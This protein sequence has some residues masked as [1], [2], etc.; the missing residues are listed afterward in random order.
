MKHP[1][2]T[3]TGCCSSDQIMICTFISSSNWSSYI[4]S[5]W[6]QSHEGFS[7]DCLSEALSPVRPSSSGC[8]SSSRISETLLMFSMLPLHWDMRRSW[9]HNG[10]DVSSCTQVRTKHRLRFCFCWDITGIIHFLKKNLHSV[11]ASEGC[12]LGWVEP[13]GGPLSPAGETV[14][15]CLPAI[16]ILETH[17]RPKTCWKLK[18]IKHRLIN[19]NLGLL[20][21]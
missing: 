4:P 10:H 11:P 17:G 21:Q 19:N 8:S 20:Y 9:R 15:L 16:A 13:R 12:W 1:R 5:P 7:P 18:H 2:Q 6:T 14:F 3:F